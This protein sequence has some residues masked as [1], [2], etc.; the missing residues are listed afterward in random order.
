MIWILEGVFEIE[1]SWASGEDLIFRIELFSKQSEDK[2]LIF[3]ARQLRYDVFKVHPAFETDPEFQTA[4][5]RWA[6][7]HVDLDPAPPE[8]VSVDQAI[9]W[10][11]EK[12]ISQSRKIEE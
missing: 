4:I 8:I 2:T 10:Y 7:V 1:G 9:A 6:I 12:V 3:K 5:H 11:Q